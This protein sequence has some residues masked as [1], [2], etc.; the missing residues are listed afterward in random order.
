[1]KK[2]H[3]HIMFFF[4]QFL[5]V[6]EFSFGQDIE[7]IKIIVKNLSRGKGPL[8]QRTH[9]V[10]VCR[11]DNVKVCSEE[12][13]VA[14]DSSYTFFISPFDQKFADLFENGNLK[15]ESLVVYASGTPCS[16]RDRGDRSFYPSTRIP[17]NTSQEIRTIEVYVNRWSAFLV[18]GY[19]VLPS[20]ACSIR[21][22]DAHGF[23]KFAII[24]FSKITESCKMGRAPIVAERTDILPYSGFLPA[25]HYLV[26]GLWDDRYTLFTLESI[27]HNGSFVK[28]DTFCQEEQDREIARLTENLE[29]KVKELEEGHSN[30]E[31]HRTI[32]AI[33]QALS[34]TRSLLSDGRSSLLPQ[35]IR[36][37]IHYSVADKASPSLP[38][39]ELGDKS[40]EEQHALLK[41]SIAQIEPI[42]KEVERALTK[43]RIIYAYKL[44]SGISESLDNQDRSSNGDDD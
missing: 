32:A 12:A 14:Y 23:T 13:H 25:E 42:L 20:A 21:Y 29:S 35:S 11:A 34:M 4:L 41:Q 22:K 33:D 31:W 6:S 5:I 26:T 43:A 40:K 30:L 44:A 24:P 37:F 39:V 38:K 15:Q 3:V 2:I 7:G 19:P 18:L 28:E 8:D 1:M 9:T 17:F 36:N 16:H 27:H 10:N